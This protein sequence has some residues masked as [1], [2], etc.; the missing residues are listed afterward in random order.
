MNN[1]A[2]TELSKCDLSC[3]EYDLFPHRSKPN[4]IR[5]RMIFTMFL[6]DFSCF[7]V[8]LNTTR[9]P[10]LKLKL[11][12]HSCVKLLPGLISKPNLA[13]FYSVLDHSGK[14]WNLSRLYSQSVTTKHSFLPDTDTVNI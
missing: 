10:V 8:A 11:V 9:L 5:K 14:A 4:L 12:C 1:A 13:V 6:H 3:K 2:I 7:S